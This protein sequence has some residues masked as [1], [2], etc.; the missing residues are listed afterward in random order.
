MEFASIVARAFFF[1]L[2][3]IVS[4]KYNINIVIR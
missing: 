3:N 4:I 2:L 1:F